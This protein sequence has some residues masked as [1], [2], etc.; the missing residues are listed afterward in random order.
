MNTQLER[1]AQLAK[2]IAQWAK[3]LEDGE[4][5]ESAATE[6]LQATGTEE[7][8]LYLR[9]LFCQLELAMSE[10]RNTSRKRDYQWRIVMEKSALPLTMKPW[11]EVV[12]G[13]RFVW[14]T[15][16][17]RRFKILTVESVALRNGLV[18]LKPQGCCY[19][20]DAFADA[21]VVVEEATAQAKAA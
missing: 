11:G 18:T 9:M 21:P 16:G 19:L 2:S 14:R 20:I 13:D 5:V 8:A 4:A 7:P 3:T 17:A 1:I 12:P 15:L 10:R 6:L